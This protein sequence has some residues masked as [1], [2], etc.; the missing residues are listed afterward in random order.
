MGCGAWQVQRTAATGGRALAKHNA[1]GRGGWAIGSGSAALLGAQ[2]RVG[3]GAVGSGPQVSAGLRTLKIAKSMSCQAYSACD[4]ERRPQAGCLAAA[5][6]HA[7]KR[8]GCAAA[9]GSGSGDH[10]AAFF[11]VG[12][13][14]RR[15]CRVTFGTFRFCS[16]EGKEQPKAGSHGGGGAWRVLLRS[17]AAGGVQGCFAG[18]GAGGDSNM[19]LLPP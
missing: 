12:S 10:A 13:L 2:W 4:K 15:S 18:A 19:P 11:Q 14:A 6:G 8:Q 16:A 1:G 7:I 9:C 17:M 5:G 3:A